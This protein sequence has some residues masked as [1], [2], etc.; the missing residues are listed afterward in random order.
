M[1]L[2]LY[3]PQNIQMDADGN[4]LFFIVDDFVYDR[5]GNIIEGP[6]GTT[7][8]NLSAFQRVSSVYN[9]NTEVN[10]PGSPQASTLII[11]DKNDCNLFHIIRK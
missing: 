3:I 10:M 1:V 7:L 6:D 2:L 8:Y 9:F 5:N 4:I 11:P